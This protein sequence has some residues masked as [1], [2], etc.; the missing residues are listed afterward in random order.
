[1]PLMS[2]GQRKQCSTSHTLSPEGI[3][4]VA[5]NKAPATERETLFIANLFP[6]DCPNATANAIVKQNGTFFR[7]SR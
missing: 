5:A 1:M 3:L 7:P 2:D 6:S 4:T